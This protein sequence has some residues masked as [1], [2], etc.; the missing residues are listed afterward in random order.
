MEKIKRFGHQFT[1]D[2][3]FDRVIDFHKDP[4][5]LKILTPPPVFVTFNLSGSNSNSSISDFYLWFGP[6]TQYLISEFDLMPGFIDRQMKGPFEFWE[7]K[8]IFRKID[9]YTTQ[10]IDHIKARPGRQ[11]LSGQI[12]RLMWL[13]LPLLFVYRARRTRDELE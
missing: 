2:A 6:D 3:P 13:S 1:V 4:R 10:I 12:S 5:A 7:H 9:P 11:L 8:H